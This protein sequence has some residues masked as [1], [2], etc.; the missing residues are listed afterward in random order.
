MKFLVYPSLFFRCL[1]FANVI[2]IIFKN[3]GI[4]SY[5][6]KSSFFQ[7]PTDPIPDFMLP[8]IYLHFD[9]RDTDENYGLKERN[10]SSKAN[11]DITTILG[12][13]L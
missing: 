9:I 3:W 1:A 2:Y 7:K 12:A 11:I 6:K 4:V 8:P 10:R 5:G 13:T